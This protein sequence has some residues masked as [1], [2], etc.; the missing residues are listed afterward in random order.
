M[1]KIK[2]PTSKY[3]KMVFISNGIICRIVVLPERFYRLGLVWQQFLLPMPS[4]LKNRCHQ[5]KICDLWSIKRNIFCVIKFKVLCHWI[6]IIWM[7]KSAKKL[8]M[9]YL[10]TQIIQ[11]QRFSHPNQ[12][13]FTFSHSNNRYSMTKYLKLNNIMSFSVM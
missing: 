2:I 9:G 6:S 7:T 4:I 12:L 5:A 10:C 8:K 11:F 1:L 3:P 13:V